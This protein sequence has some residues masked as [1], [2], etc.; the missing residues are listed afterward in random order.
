MVVVFSLGGV[1][2]LGRLAYLQAIK[3]DYYETLGAV[4][5]NR[6]VTLAAN[7]GSIVDRN[8]LIL[9]M[10]ADQQS[11]WA[12]PTLVVDAEKEAALLAGPL[13]RDAAELTKLLSTKS[14]FVYIERKA[15]NEVAQAIQKLVDGKKIPGVYLLN[16][17][18][19]F[20]PADD[21]GISIIGAVDVDNNGISGLELQYQQTL[22][23]T[24]GKEVIEKDKNGN[25]ISSARRTGTPA[26]QGQGI[27][28]TLDRSLQYEIDKILIREVNRNHARRATAIV[29]NR[30]T[31]D[32][33]AVSNVDRGAQK[34]APEPIVVPVPD[35]TAA[36][37]TLP[38]DPAAPA[39][40]VDPAVAATTLPAAP[41]VP[42]PPPPVE[43]ESAHTAT[44]NYATTD[45]FEPGS[46]NKLVTLAAA[47]E[48]GT[49][50]IDS[51][52]DVPDAIVFDNK[53]FTDHI[54]GLPKQMT[55]DE[56]I[57]QSSNF[58]TIRMAEKLG[59]KR[60]DAYLRRFGFASASE[61][62]FPGE[63]RGLLLDLKN[64]SE[65]DIGS[66]P[67]GQGLS[68]TAIQMVAA[69]NAIANGGVYV[70]P[71]LVL[72]TIDGHGVQ[73]A[74]PATA[75]HRVVSAATAAGVTRVLQDVVT[76]VGGTGRLAAVDG[77]TV[78]GKTGT[79]KVPLPGGLGYED[80]AY[81]TGF[82][83]F[84]PAINPEYTILITFD[85]P[86]RVFGA[87]GDEIFVATDGTKILPTGGNLAAPVFADVAK[88]VL[89]TYQVPPAGRPS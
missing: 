89:R 45:V 12:D 46:M 50:K 34:P 35:T 42:P 44:V 80:N 24:P 55:V 25:T 82:T 83:G 57:S 20:S 21:L 13:K 1:V 3:P 70:P 39:T 36:P 75:G 23:G 19:R 6:I 14:S 74:V 9:A 87:N 7:R 84:V 72:S 41:V 78:A 66:V 54:S 2:L 64:W 79:A 59:P 71:R 22:K 63:S 62:G 53:K 40:T 5:R 29:M 37:T 26:V 88:V 60:L 61:L 31:G 16:E 77:Y 38:V 47:L 11:I 67:L 32:I 8:G 10:S 76:G 15:E 17:P 43:Y 85:H 27:Q 18:K 51:V 33:V 48:E 73:H 49:A 4:Q 69:F 30:R 68:V 65:S 81:I 28:L 52:V 86:E 56:I 58:G